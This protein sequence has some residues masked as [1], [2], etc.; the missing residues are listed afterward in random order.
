MTTPTLVRTYATRRDA[1]AYGKDVRDVTPRRELGILKPTERDP[2]QHLIEQN[3]DRVQD[4]VPLRMA[5]MLQSPFAFYRGTAGLMALDLSDDPHSGIMVI[6]CGD[7]H[8]SNFGFYASPERRLV[9]DLNDF[10]EAAAAPWEWDLKRLVTSAVVGGRH[11]GYSE[12]SI[13]EVAREAVRSYTFTLDKLSK[14]SPA[15]RYFMH[16]GGPYTRRKL[17]KSAQRALDEAVKAA[18]R[19]TAERAIKRT[20]ERGP[21][22]KLRFIENPPTM[23]HV[24]RESAESLQDLVGRYRSTVSVDIELVISQYEPLDLVQRVVGV[25]SVGT[26]CAL[27]LM[28]GADNDLLLLQVKEATESVLVKYG[29]VAQP[30]RITAGVEEHGN[31]Y[32]VVGLQ[33]ILQGVSDPYLGYLR[34]DHRDFYVRQFHDMKGSIELEGL[35]VGTFN[36][37]VA[38][39]ASLLARAHAQSPAAIEIVGYIGKGDAAAEAIT[40]WSYAYA[41]QSLRDFKKLRAAADEGRVPLADIVGPAD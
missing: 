15:H 17:D 33:R 31:G 20:T 36:A 6:A 24:D 32:R 2:V 19:R 39:C 28:A 5:R 23:T 35:E 13:E 27:H 37:Y 21:D 40:R 7:A 18:E 3:A 22:G 11:A 4:L 26:R 8:I 1:R 38:A 14:L 16:S 41:D 12:A 30:P 9:F 29:K 10:D 34:T 25:G